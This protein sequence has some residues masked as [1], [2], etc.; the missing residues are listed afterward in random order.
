M[1]EAQIILPQTMTAQPA[2]ELRKGLLALFG[3]YTEHEATGAWVDPATGK[4]YRDHSTVFSIAGEQFQWAELLPLIKRVG[5]M[6][7]QIC[8]YA[9]DFES[10]VHFI[11]C[12]A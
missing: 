8:I 4:I 12:G 1:R 6:A 5:A 3:G 11:D 9:T 2:I 7:K 10:E